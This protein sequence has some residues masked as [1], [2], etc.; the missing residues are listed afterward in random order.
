MANRTVILQTNES[1]YNQS[2]WNDL[3]LPLSLNCTTILNENAHEVFS[4]YRTESIKVI[5]AVYDTFY[6]DLE[7][8]IP[9]DISKT[10]RRFHSDPQLWWAGQIASYILRPSERLRQYIAE[11]KKTL[12]FTD[13]IVGLQIRRTDKLSEANYYNLTEYMK[14]ADNWFDNYENKT[15]TTGKKRTIFIATDD[16]GV[17]KEARQKFSDHTIIN[18]IDVTVAASKRGTRYQ[19]SSLV[20]IILDTFLLSM[21]DY[22]VCT[23][24]SNICRLAFELMQIRHIDATTDAKSLDCPYFIQKLYKRHCKIRPTRL[25]AVEKMLKGVF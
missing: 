9:D 10:I 13:V 14:A 21:C 18:D 6:F 20:G 25:S 22:I 3:F 5:K 12:G 1:K 15:G 23:M 24:T 19:Y 2:G 8:A 17:V 11:K 16:P 4:L 7:R